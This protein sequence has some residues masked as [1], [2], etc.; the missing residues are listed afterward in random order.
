MM[1]K[2]KKQI[3]P[4]DLYNAFNEN[5]DKYGNDIEAAIQLLKTKYEAKVEILEE[6]SEF[7]GMYFSIPEMRQNMSKYPEVVCVESTYKIFNLRFS[8]M[9]FVIE[10]GEGR[11]QIVGVG[12]L[13][14][15]SRPIVKWLM[16]CFKEDNLEAVKKTRGFISDKDL[17]E[18]SVIREVFDWARLF[19]CQFHTLR[20]FD[21]E[22][23][24]TKMKITKEEKE[25]ALRCLDSMVKSSYQMDYDNAHSKFISTAP[26][27]I[28]DYFIKNWQDITDEWVKFKIFNLN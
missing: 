4:Q 22:I 8:L 7:Q 1:D 17:T 6:N 9:L 2:T 5:K 16:E 27:V 24:P 18:R 11:S 26:K 3:I 23:C 12:I 14:S 10:D 15:E 28:K 25:N 20:I 21:R 13:V 19:I